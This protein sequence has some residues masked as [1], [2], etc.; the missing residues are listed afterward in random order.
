MNDSKLEATT[1]EGYFVRDPPT[2][3][4]ESVNGR[5]SDGVLR[6]FVL[7]G[8]SKMVYDAVPLIVTP[9]PVKPNSLRISLKASDIP[10]H[11]AGTHLLSADTTV[12]IESFDRKDRLL[13]HD[14]AIH[15]INMPSDPSGDSPIPR[16][17]TMSANFPSEPPAARLRIVVL[18]NETGKIGAENSLLGK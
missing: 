16:T 6:D 1:R 4:S 10:W 13:N 17:V 7:A 5:P 8:Q 3:V 2:T 9:D 11:Q 14:S 18:V 12:L 15:T